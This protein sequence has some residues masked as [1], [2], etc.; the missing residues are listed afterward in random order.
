M[1]RKLRNFA[2]REER[3]LN[4][5]Y[6]CKLIED[7]KNDSSSMWKAIKRTLPSNHMN[8]NDI[9]ANGKLHASSIG[10]AEHLNQHLFNI[11]RYLAKSFRNTS[12][13]LAENVTS[14]YGL[15]KLSFQNLYDVRP[16]GL[17]LVSRDY[18]GKRVNPSFI[19]SNQGNPSSVVFR[20]GT[21]FFRGYYSRDAWTA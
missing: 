20:H 16:S 9:F 19:S 8:T 3:S 18:R 15:F 6:Y 21:Q 2:S 13:V 5:Q 11:G 7:A 4:S 14:A 10:I 17:S 12:S 1:Y